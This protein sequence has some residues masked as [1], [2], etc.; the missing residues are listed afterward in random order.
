MAPIELA[1]CNLSNN[2]V[3]IAELSEADPTP[4]KFW[5]RSPHNDNGVTVS[6]EVASLLLKMIETEQ[7]A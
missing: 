5:I 1:R 6:T 2:F 7:G 4:V 3:L